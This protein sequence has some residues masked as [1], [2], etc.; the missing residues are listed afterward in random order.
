[1]GA[2]AVI[3]S[4]LPLFMVIAMRRSEARIYQ[5]LVD[6]GGFTA[7]S[8]I[9]LSLGRSLDQRRLQSLIRGG[10]VRLTTDRRHYLDADGWTRHLARRR[11]RALLAVSIVATLLAVGVAVILVMR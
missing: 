1:M 2:A 8:A 4:L 7:E 10:A 9:P 6:A 5:Q 3:P 11:R